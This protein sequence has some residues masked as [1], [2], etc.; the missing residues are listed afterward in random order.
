MLS[1]RNPMA[2]A[3]RT[4]Q[5]LVHPEEHGGQAILFLREPVFSCFPREGPAAQAP[6][7]LFQSLTKSIVIGVRQPE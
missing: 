1:H 7:Y 4:L 3:P 2:S 5:L 6:N